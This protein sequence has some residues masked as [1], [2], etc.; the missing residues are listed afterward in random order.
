MHVK[1]RGIYNTCYIR[2]MN[3][4]PGISWISGETDLR[5]IDIVK[6][7]DHLLG[8]IVVTNGYHYLIVNYKMKDTTSRIIWQI[9]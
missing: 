2:A 3:A 6:T 8:S 7:I 4:G 9:S 5:L 1:Y